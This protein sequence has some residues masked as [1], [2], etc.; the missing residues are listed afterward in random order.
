[1]I[2]VIDSVPKLKQ[3]AWVIVTC[4]GFVAF[5][6]NLS[7]YSGYNRLQ[8]AGFG[9][10]DNNCNGIAII[11]CLGLAFF[12]GLNAQR[13]WQKAVAL[14]CALALAHAVFIAFSRGAM[15]AM[16]ITGALA[17]FLIPKRPK[18]ALILVV[19]V[20]LLF[21]LAGAEV[22]ERFLTTFANKEERDASADARLR[23]WQACVQ[24]VM[25]EPLLGVG[26]AHWHLVSQRY[27]LPS[28]EAHT[29]WLQLAAEQGI[30]GLV[31]LLSFYGLCILRLWPLSRE[32]CPVSD[33][34]LHDAA[35]MVIASL[36]G[37][38]VSAQFVSLQGLEVP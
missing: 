5:E 9:G 30:L 1:G 8:E 16:I 19:G 20:L 37:F 35:R 14:G 22:Q 4:E 38:M 24:A 26:P 31:L 3:L 36:T 15:L 2:T 28:M 27:G 10:M 33:P 32:S 29:L 18:H 11:T 6:M 13:W 23:N 34:W 12:L 17:F 25:E 21:R 7:Y